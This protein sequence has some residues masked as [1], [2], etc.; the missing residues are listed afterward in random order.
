MVKH[1]KTE[2]NKTTLHVAINGTLQHCFL[3]Y[4]YSCVIAD[5]RHIVLL[6][7]SLHVAKEA[8]IDYVMPIVGVDADVIG[9]VIK[10][11]FKKDST[12]GNVGVKYLSVRK[13]RQNT[14]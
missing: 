14:D 3:S 7:M 6:G 8:M 12:R 5:C 10:M 4:R 1:S 13:F 9:F 2:S 11:C